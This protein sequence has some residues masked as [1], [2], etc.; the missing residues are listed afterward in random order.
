M[1][2]DLLSVARA[3]G[4]SG[5]VGAFIFMIVIA[6]A[7]RMIAQ[8]KGRSGLLWFMVGGL[9][10]VGALLGVV[11]IPPRA[12]RGSGPMS[13]PD[14]SGTTQEEAAATVELRHARTVAFPVRDP[15]GRHVGPTVV[16]EIETWLKTQ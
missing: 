11:L 1:N 4:S 10:T 15:A 3:T 9:F 8:R 2:T 16:D 7:C 14:E 6:S 13:E 12:R 5:S